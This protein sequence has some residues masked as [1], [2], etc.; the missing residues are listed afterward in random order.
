MSN[1][2]D[3]HEITVPRPFDEVLHEAH[4]ILKASGMTIFAEIDH[5]TAARDIGMELPATVVIVY[6][7]PKAG[8][9]VMQQFPNAAL[10]L[11]L[12]VLLREVSPSATV[13]AL[14]P[15]ADALEAAGA[16]PELGER[17]LPGQRLLLDRFQP[18]VTGEA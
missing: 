15:I 1:A 2:S 12:R 18:S 14:H 10:D 6:G 16:P 4:E 5:A 3:I 8:T 11:P 13:V 17:L 7:N 9:P